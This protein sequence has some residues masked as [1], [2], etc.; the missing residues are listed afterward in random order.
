[1]SY[2]ADPRFLLE[3]EKYGAVNI[4]SCFNCGNCT[5]VCP[6]STEGENFPRRMIRYAQVGMKEK[7]LSS[8]ELWLCYYC[9][10]CTAT[11]PRQAEPGEFMAAAR[12]YAIA[13][14]DRL[15]LARLLYTSAAFNTMFLTLLAIA[16][17]VFLYAFHGPM[18]SDTLRLFDFIPSEVVHNLGVMAGIIVVL[19]ALSGLANMV[20]Q[21]GKEIRFGEGGRFNWLPALWETMTEV[22]GQ[23]RYRRD[24]EAY[25]QEQPRFLQQ[26]FIHASMLWG[27]LGLFLATALDYLL[28]LIGVKPTGTWVPIWYPIRL[29]GTLAGIMLMYGVMLAIFK[30]LRQADESSTHSTPS[31]WAFLILL[32]LS[33]ITGFALEVSIYLPQ[34]YAWSYWMLL[35]HLIVVGELL[36]LLPFTKFAHAIYRTVALYLHILKPVPETKRVGAGAAA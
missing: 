28:E 18:P 16:M 27:F 14:Y 7:M 17:G 15:G 26:W 22:L 11:C 13:R 12:R 31:D 23:Q 19:I 32:W 8:K 10:E 3:L 30:R 29:L 1:M 36:I 9:G 4:E 21:V 33:G 2:R 35:A 25:A 5:A 24:C 34:P 6:L 20:V